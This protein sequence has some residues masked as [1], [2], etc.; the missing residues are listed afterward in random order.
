M[1]AHLLGAL[2]LAVV[3]TGDVRKRVSEFAAKHPNMKIVEVASIAMIGGLISST[4]PSLI[5]VPAFFTVMDDLQCRMARIFGVRQ[6]T[7]AG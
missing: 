4:I 6:Q 7:E 5:Y 2:A 1:R 3:L